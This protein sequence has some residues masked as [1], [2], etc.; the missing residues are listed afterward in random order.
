MRV[1][2]RVIAMT[3]VMLSARENISRDIADE[4]A[5]IIHFIIIDLIISPSHPTYLWCRKIQ[6][7]LRKF[8]AFYY[9]IAEQ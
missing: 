5:W 6:K 1:T 4:M 2:P 9:T 7:Q 8:Y 3:T